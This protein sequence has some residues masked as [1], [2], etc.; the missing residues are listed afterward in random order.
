M[1][2]DSRRNP[3]LLKIYQRYLKKQ[4]SAAF[5]LKVSQLYTQGTLE[6]LTEHDFP[7]VRRAA[8]LALGFTGDYSANHALGMA[9]QDEDR[10]VRMLSE[11]GIRN[12]WTRAGNEDQRRQ[13]ATIV[14]FN[15]SKRYEEAIQQ[16]TELL[17]KAAWFAEIW[18]QRAIAYFA[19]NRFAEAIHD[20]H[21]ALEINPYHF[22]AAAG[23][24][25]AYLQLGN[26]AGAL[27]SFRRAAVEPGSG[28]GSRTSR[29][30]DP[31]YRR[32]GRA[33]QR[34]RGRVLLVSRHG[35][36]TG[37]TPDYSQSKVT[38]ATESLR[39]ESGLRRFGG[40]E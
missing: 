31:S 24:G 22:G 21:Q 13:L 19:T 29:P 14:R 12:V 18:N 27:E 6:R 17:R 16:A 35:W 1:S 3:F 20:C 11:N 34:V 37:G 30:A 8:V 26:H 32:E 38:R 7:P 23:M 40:G 39:L 9:L 4:D 5:I 28:G 25:Q 33:R 36:N 15:A 2:D 10:T